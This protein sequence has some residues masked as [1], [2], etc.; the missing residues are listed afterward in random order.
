VEKPRP[1]KAPSIWRL[2]GVTCL[3]PQDFALF[4]RA[5]SRERE[6]NIQLT[7]APAHSWRRKTACGRTFTRR[8]NFLRSRAT[9]G[10]SEG[11]GGNRLQNILSLG[12]DFRDYLKN[13]KLLGA[14]KSM[15][16]RILGIESLCDETGGGRGGP[17]GGR[18]FQRGG[19]TDRHSSK[20]GGV[21]PGVGFRASICAR[22]CR[23]CGKR[24][25]KQ[26]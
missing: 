4:W 15:S 17:T 7:D 3:P 19:F 9:S 12:R 24:L 26:G 1:E 11:D 2:P 14:T 22:S 25:S 21:V 16:A 23:W 8:S 5:P 6:T 13:L 10:I 20:Y 18:F